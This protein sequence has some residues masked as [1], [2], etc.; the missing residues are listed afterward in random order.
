MLNRY[1]FD[2][3]FVRVCII[4][5][6]TIG[7]MLLGGRQRNPSEEK[8][9]LEVISKNFKRTVTPS[10]L[11]GYDGGVGSL[12]SQQ[13][14]EAIKVPLPSEFHHLVW[15]PELLRMAILVHRAMQFKEPVLLIGNTG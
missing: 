15:T 4:P 12:A 8:V 3:Y 13:I 10:K 2:L 1:S 5:F 7:Y 9:I 14:L 11:F 6:L